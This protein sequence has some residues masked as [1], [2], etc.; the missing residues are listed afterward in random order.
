MF[1]PIA[2]PTHT[3]LQRN[4]LLKQCGGVVSLVPF[5]RFPFLASGYGGWTPSW[6]AGGR[7]GG[8]NDSTKVVLIIIVVVGLALALRWIY[9]RIHEFAVTAARHT[10]DVVLDYRSGA[11]DDSVE[12]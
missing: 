1:L 4:H 5:V 8:G 2:P 9:S 7:S 10:Q 12:K 11:R 6:G 3:R